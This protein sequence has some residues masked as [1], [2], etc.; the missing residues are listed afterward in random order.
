M[1]C[2]RTFRLLAVFIV[3]AFTAGCDQATKH[4][5]RTELA[6]FNAASLS[7]G[8]IELGLAENPGAFLSLGA[9]LPE[10]ARGALLTAGIAVGLTALLIY[11]LRATTLRW[12]SFFGFV[13]IWAGGISNL[14]DR[15][16]H[17]GLVTDF[18]LLRV[19]A[20][21]TG[22]FN[23][24]DLG[25]VTGAIILVASFNMRLSRSEVRSKSEGE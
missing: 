16:A 9:S 12:L 25:I 6:H 19:G 15:F 21:R 20:F 24:A 23:V 13:Q 22:V 14:I 11:L 18:I 2:S 1:T 17:H 7:G 4:L 8:F 5:A 3:L 10:P